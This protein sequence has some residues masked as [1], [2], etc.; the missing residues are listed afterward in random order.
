MTLTM[1]TTEFRDRLSAILDQVESGQQTVFITRRGHAQAV[2]ISS[3][4]YETLIRQ[5]NPEPEP[6]FYAI[7]QASLAR[8]WEHPDEDVYTWE[9]GE[10]L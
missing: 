10:P 3:A 6:S 7:S 9:D 4:E 2:L 8:I 1:P 5:H